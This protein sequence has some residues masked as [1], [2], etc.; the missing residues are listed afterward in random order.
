M[1]RVCGTLAAGP[2]SVVAT[3]GMSRSNKGKCV[4]RSLGFS[5]QES[6]CGSTGRSFIKGTGG[7]QDVVQVLRANPESK[8][9]GMARTALV[10]ANP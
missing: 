4:C 3:G 6:M 1:L 8:P 2:L 7:G 10:E 9:P 5:E